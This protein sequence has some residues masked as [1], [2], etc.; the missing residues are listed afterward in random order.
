MTGGASYMTSTAGLLPIADVTAW[1]RPWEPDGVIQSGTTPFFEQ[2]GLDVTYT[3]EIATDS[4]PVGFLG[5]VSMRTPA[6]G[7]TLPCWS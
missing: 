7:A 2:S 4:A 1:P 5:Q 3:F 6:T